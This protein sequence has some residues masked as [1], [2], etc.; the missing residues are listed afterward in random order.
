MEITDLL[1]RKC[2][3]KRRSRTEPPG[4]LTFKS[5]AEKELLIKGIEINKQTRRFS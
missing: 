1:Q 4:I 3:I 2:S 5:N